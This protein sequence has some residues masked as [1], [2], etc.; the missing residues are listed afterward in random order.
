LDYFDYIK[1]PLWIERK[2][3]YYKTHPRKC[4][5]CGV[6][7]N[8]QLHHMIYGNFGKEPDRHLVTLCKKCHSDFHRIYLVH[9]DMLAETKQFIETRQNTIRNILNFK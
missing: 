1:S 4:A 8:I 3:R 5:A 6:N 2:R 9:R 7:R